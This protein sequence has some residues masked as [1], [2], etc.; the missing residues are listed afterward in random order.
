LIQRFAPKVATPGGVQRGD[1]I[2]GAVIDTILHESGHGIF[3]QL[4]IPVMGR[5]EDAADFF[6]IYFMLQFPPADARR[7]I[8]GIAFNMGSEARPEVLER[9][10]P[11]QEPRPAA[12]DTAS[13]N[14]MRGH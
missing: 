9:Q 14:T 3:D 6:S 5:E 8:E 10:A 7:L 13:N 11:P 4:E 2:V 12:K 1:A